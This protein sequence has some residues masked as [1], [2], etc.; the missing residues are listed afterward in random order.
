[1]KTH[2]LFVVTF[3]LSLVLNSQ[4][5]EIFY[6]NKLN[7]AEPVLTEK[8]PK[9]QL[10]VE[11]KKPVNPKEKHNLLN[12]KGT[13]LK[14]DSI[15]S[16]NY[17][18]YYTYDSR[19]NLVSHE[20]WTKFDDVF[21]ITSRH[22]YVF[23]ENNNLKE[24]I[25]SIGG[26]NYFELDYKYVYTYDNLNRVILEEEYD[27]GGT[28][29]EKYA[30]YEYQYDQQGNLSLILSYVGV[31]NEWQYSYKTIQVFNSNNLITLQENYYWSEG[32]WKKDFK[33]VFDYDVY[34]NQVLYISYFGPEEWIPST[35]E[36]F[37]YIT[38]T[39]KML[40]DN[41]YS[42]DYATYSWILTFKK[43]FFY[44]SNLMDT[45]IIE[46][47]ANDENILQNYSKVQKSYDAN[48]NLIDIK[49][50]YASG[51]NWIPDRRI[52]YA[53]NSAN[54]LTLVINYY[55]S[56]NFN[57]WT[58][59]NKYTYS[60]DQLNNVTLELSYFFDG[61]DWIY[62]YKSEYTYDYNL[63]KL[64]QLENYNWVIFTQ[65]WVKYFRYFYEYDSYGDNT[66]FEYYNAANDEWIP[67]HKI[68][69][70]YKYE[71]MTSQVVTPMAYFF[72]SI[73]V[74]DVVEEYYMGENNTFQLSDKFYYY[75]SLGE[76]VGFENV[77]LNHK[78]F[79]PNPAI[80]YVYLNFQ[81]DQKNVKVYSLKGELVC[82]LSLNGN[83]V[84]LPANLS[85]G[86]YLFKI[87][88]LV[89]KIYIKK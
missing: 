14:L 7:N 23:D 80:N 58:P 3:F 11:V 53:Y 36:V 5:Y 77:V 28:E 73:H 61:S 48:N 66:N 75:Y 6:P 50:Y 34:G 27:W 63:N 43:E 64:I 30:K 33:I 54:L 76:F 32:M 59:D 20:V 74:P 9:N 49:Y 26:V 29:W 10:Q 17:K 84:N 46:Q 16:F 87:G 65:S 88:N 2:F 51:A 86:I 38:G 31:N 13:N 69:S 42:W 79:Y 71:Y 52:E 72:N 15:I 45:L 21:W 41:V 39:N 12:S 89:E 57:G 47:K 56:Y 4:K 62:N 55:W 85:E 25:I 78:L 19:K 44:N 35:K 37:E 70:T 18:N 82:V 8:T 83:R 67:Y 68:T 24:Y 40:L 1:M 22:E 81:T 60:Y